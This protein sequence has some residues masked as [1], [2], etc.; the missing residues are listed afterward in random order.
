MSRAW[1]WGRLASMAEPPMPAEPLTIEYYSDVLCVWAW[2][3]ER[4]NQELEEAF[5][6][7]LRFNCHYLDV[8]SDTATRIGKGWAEKGGYVGFGQHVKDAAAPYEDAPVHAQLWEK[9]QPSTSANAHLVIKATGLIA[10]GE[11]A[12]KLARNLRER[13]F[14]HA[15]DIGRLELVLSAAEELGVERKPLRQA[16]DGGTPMAALLADNKLAET[17]NI[18]G[19]P[20]WLMNSGRQVLYGNVGYRVLHVNV[21]ECLRRPAHEASWC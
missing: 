8:F 6:E 4:R 15:E 17:H 3:A 18:Q 11:T 2:I 10:D 9:S 16:I 12:R 14:V 1:D 5:G 7:Q 19:S 21:E 20:S 13:F